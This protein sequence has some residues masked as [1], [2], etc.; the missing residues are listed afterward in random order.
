MSK[1]GARHLF[2]HDADLRVKDGPWAIK[3]SQGYL[4][5]TEWAS[6]YGRGYIVFTKNLRTADRYESRKQAHRALVNVLNSRSF[7]AK[8]FKWLEVV[9]LYGWENM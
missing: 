5:R 6:M 8:P 7:T 2:R 9:P 4:I 1:R 3:A